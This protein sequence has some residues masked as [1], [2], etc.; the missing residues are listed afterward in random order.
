MIVPGLAWFLPAAAAGPVSR[1]HDRK[2]MILFVL[3]LILGGA[4]V[5]WHD[6]PVWMY[7]VLIGVTGWRMSLRRQER[8]E[9]LRASE[10]GSTEMPSDEEDRPP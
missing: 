2:R 10:T 3:V 8:A 4:A 9:R 6:F 7:A 1:Y 5:W